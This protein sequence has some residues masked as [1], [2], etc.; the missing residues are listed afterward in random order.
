M[1]GLPFKRSSNLVGKAGALGHENLQG[2]M[3]RKY[4]RQC[5][6]RLSAGKRL[7]GPYTSR[8][9][10]I[11]VFRIR[12]WLAMH[13]FEIEQPIDYAMNGCGKRSCTL[14][15]QQLHALPMIV[16]KNLGTKALPAI[17]YDAAA[18]VISDFLEL[19]S[20]QQCG[21]TLQLPFRHASF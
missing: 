4:K 2:E 11:G 14:C 12:K 3:R 7:C 15:V 20:I 5:R 21:E 9:A 18:R 6:R 1:P 17:A 19:G 13:R 10:H 8:W 16:T